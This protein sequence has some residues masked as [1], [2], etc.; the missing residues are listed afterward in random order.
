MSITYTQSKRHDEAIVFAE[1]ARKLS[2][3]KVFI[4]L[5]GY[6][7]AMA[8]RR[9]E[10]MEL[11]AELKKLSDKELSLYPAVIAIY[12]IGLGE[13]DQAF[14]W[15]DIAYKEK[16]FLIPYIN[17]DPRFDPVRSDPRFIE[18]LKKIGLDK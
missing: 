9:D 7:Y 3:R 13:F 4:P 1:K 15:L 14:R 8:D 16:N 18:L 12:Y 2:K 5:I 10:A 17:N 6:A 11:F